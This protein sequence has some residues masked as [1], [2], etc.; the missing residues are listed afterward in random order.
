MRVHMCIHV[1]ISVYNIYIYLYNKIFSHH[2]KNEI[3]LFATT[4][5]KLEGIMLSEISQTGK[6]KY[7][8]ISFIMWNLKKKKKPNSITARGWRVG[9]N[10]EMFAEGYKVPV[11]G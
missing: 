5:M 8:M 1:C 2:K 4:W 6:E 9:K 3:L 10:K 11:I 7:C